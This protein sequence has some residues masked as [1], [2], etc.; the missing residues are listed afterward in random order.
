M[1]RHRQRYQDV[2]ELLDA[3]ISVLTSINLQDIEEQQDFVRSVT[4]Q[5]SAHT[6]PQGF[7]TSA[8]ELVVVDAPLDV[9]LPSR[10][11]ATAAPRPRREPIA[12]LNSASVR[13]C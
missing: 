1:V 13:S 7:V 2:E 4:G 5:S 3:G 11:V 8:D 9:K 12:C 10:S 6:V